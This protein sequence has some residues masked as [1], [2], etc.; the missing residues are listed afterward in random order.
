MTPK[1]AEGE[2]WAWSIGVSDWP[3]GKTDYDLSAN[4]A[5]KAVLGLDRY[6]EHAMATLS[7]TESEDGASSEA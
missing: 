3:I 7:G 2:S 1:A 6:Y 5:V 4:E